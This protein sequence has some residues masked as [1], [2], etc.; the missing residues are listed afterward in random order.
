MKLLTKQILKKLPKLY[1]TE[2]QKDPVAFVK[3]FN[4]CGSQSWFATEFDG[5]DV[6]FGKIVGQET[7]LG[8]FSLSELQNVQLRFGL[9]IER[10]LYFEPKPLSECN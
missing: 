7:E 5:G 4:P 9:G 1:T 10:D 8:Y 3:F 2:K 6:F